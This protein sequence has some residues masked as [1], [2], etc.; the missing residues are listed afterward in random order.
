MLAHSTTPGG[1]LVPRSVVGATH[2]N[3]YEHYVLLIIVVD[4]VHCHHFVEKHKFEENLDDSFTGQ[5]SGDLPFVGGDV[6]VRAMVAEEVHD[7]QVVS[8]GGPVQCCPAVDV[9]LGVCVHAPENS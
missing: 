9:V 6:L 7:V 4:D 8:L 2:K 5:L 3:Y 1:K